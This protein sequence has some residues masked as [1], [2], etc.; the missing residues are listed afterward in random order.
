MDPP[1]ATTI[2][3]DS[4]GFLRKIAKA[5]NEK[6]AEKCLFLLLLMYAVRVS[7]NHICRY[8]SGVFKI[9]FPLPMSS[10]LSESL[11]KLKSSQHASQQLVKVSRGYGQ[12]QPSDVCYHVSLEHSLTRGHPISF[13]H[14]TA[15]LWNQRFEKTD[16]TRPKSTFA[17]FCII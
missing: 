9:D 5:K 7:L 15:Q 10:A 3:E 6:D 4:I 13:F 17:E 12:S 11:P 8:L 16:F 1:R 14:R 2:R